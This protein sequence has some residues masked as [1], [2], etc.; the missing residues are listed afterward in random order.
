MKGKAILLAPLLVI[1]LA[2]CN[3]TNET[4]NDQLMIYTSIYPIQFVAEEITG[5][6]AVVKSIYP[7]GVDAHTYEPTS[8]E[9]TEIANGDAFIYLGSGMESFA[10]TAADAL[11]SQEIL[12]IEIGEHEHLFAKD[13]HDNHGH[14]HDHGDHDPHIWLDPLRMV[15][16]GE[17]IKNELVS[18]NP[19]KEDEYIT[20]FEILKK[21]LTKLDE[22]FTAT[23][24]A[25][26]NKQILVSHAAYGYWEERY[27]IE[28]I[29]I[30][31]LTS[32]D[33]PSQKDLAEIARLAENEDLTYVIYEQTGSNRLA[34]I[35]Q[36]YIHAEK[37]TIHNLE[38]LTEDDIAENENYLSL[39]EKNLEVLN[40]ATK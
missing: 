27:G 35:I 13:D 4:R 3:S 28:Q 39:M 25:K 12:F 29:P 10:E 7:P 16:I 22:D 14:D 6:E 2:A 23:L 36:E 19:E 21:N 38:V 24:N 31:G 30:N 17:I 32:S 11:Q 20:N 37:L 5:D 40:Q 9:I 8:R 15:E 18:L 34:S 33:E 1:L 26:D